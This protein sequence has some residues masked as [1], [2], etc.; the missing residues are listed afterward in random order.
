MY[1][2]MQAACGDVYDVSNLLWPKKKNRLRMIFAA[3]TPTGSFAQA[4]WYTGWTDFEHP[5]SA[6]DFATHIRDAAQSGATPITHFELVAHAHGDSSISDG[7]GH[8]FGISRLS[9]DDLTQTKHPY[10]RARKRQGPA[11]CWFAPSIKMMV[12]SLRVKQLILEL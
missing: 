7:A 2:N 10:E 4:R 6:V 9:A 5:T 12:L 1:A 11:R 3:D 8:V